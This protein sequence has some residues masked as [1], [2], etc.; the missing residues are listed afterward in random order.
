VA[1]AGRLDLLTNSLTEFVTEPEG[2]GMKTNPRA[3]SEIKQYVQSCVLVR[4]D[5]LTVNNRR[6][7]LAPCFA[8]GNDGDSVFQW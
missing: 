3:L 7:D 8:L 1:I 2:Q 6:S 5:G 4:A